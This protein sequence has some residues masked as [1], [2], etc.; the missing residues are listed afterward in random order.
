MKSPTTG[1]KLHTFTNNVIL[2][3]TSVGAP[4]ADHNNY[5]HGKQGE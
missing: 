1:G 5:G 4:R 3:G 2:G